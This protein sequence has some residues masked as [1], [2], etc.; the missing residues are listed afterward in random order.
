MKTLVILTFCFVVLG[1]TTK[2][3]PEIQI[4]EVKVAVPVLCTKPNI[5]PRPNLM[6]KEQL[7]IAKAAITN[8]DDKIK[9]VA[10]Q[11]LLY[12]GWTPKVEAGLQGCVGGTVPDQ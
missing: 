6:T 10:E 8:F 4:R 1:C 7:R 12:M 5:G 2:P 3:A 9:L 11:L